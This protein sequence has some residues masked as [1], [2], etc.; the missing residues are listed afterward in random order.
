MLGGTSCLS[1]ELSFVLSA[2]A[3]VISLEASLWESCAA[4]VAV[5]LR[6]RLSEYVYFL[7]RV[8]RSPAF[9][10]FQLLFMFRPPFPRFEL[11]SFNNAHRTMKIRLVTLMRVLS[12]GPNLFRA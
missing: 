2:E 5:T 4:G 1:T 6:F 3:V 8:M 9:S 10:S 7:I 11:S 12:K